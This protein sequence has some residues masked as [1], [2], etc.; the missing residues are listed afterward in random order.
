MRKNNAV[1]VL[2]AI[3]FI[4]MPVIFVSIVVSLGPF[5]PVADAQGEIDEDTVQEG[6]EVPDGAVGDEEGGVSR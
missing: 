6:S 2:L 3:G 4:L 5:S 1:M